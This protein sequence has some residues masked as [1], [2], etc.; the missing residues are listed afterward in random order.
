MI[1]SQRHEKSIKSKKL[2]VALSRR[3]RNRILYVLKEYAGFNDERMDRTHYLLRKELGFESLKAV[4]GGHWVDTD[5][6]GFVLSGSPIFL[7][8]AIEIFLKLLPENE[9]MECQ[10]EL[11]QI[12]EV[13]KLSFRLINGKFYKIDS[14]YL[15]EEVLSKVPELLK[16]YKFDGPLIEYQSALEKYT[17]GDYPGCIVEANNAFESTLKCI[18]GEE[19]TPGELIKLL[20]KNG[21]IPNYFEGFIN[22]MK[23]ILNFVPTIRSNEG[24]HGSGAE[25]REVPESLAQFTLHLAA[26]LIVFLLRRY[27]ELQPAA[28]ENEEDDLPF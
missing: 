18:T 12:F 14:E 15:Q 2:S 7:L 17:S 20:G 5:F 4:V 21:F 19:K 24:G 25:P 6:E 28:E 11:N 22:A 9:M 10:K 13:E 1:F 8:D 27:A 26:T 16:E 23:K 3:L